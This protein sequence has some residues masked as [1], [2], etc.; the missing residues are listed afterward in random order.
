MNEEQETTS[1]ET[2]REETKP[3]APSLFRNFVSF[4]G[5]AVVVA[6]LTSIALLVLV[7]FSGGSDNPYTVLVTYILLPSVMGFGFLVATVGAL[8][9]RRRRR[10]SPVSS[11]APY[12]ILDLNDPSRRRSLLALIAG[13]FVFLF[14]SAFGS[15]RAFEYTES[16]SFCGEQCHTV[17]KPEFISH[18][19]APHASI[20]C[21]DCHVG[22]GPEWY[23]RSKMNGMRQLYAVAFNTYDRPI[24]TPI[25]NMRNANETCAKC[26]WP[27]KYYG[28]KL[29][30]FNHF[31]YDENNTLRQIRLMLKVGGGSP[32]RGEIGGIH[33]HMNLDN[34]ITYIAADERRQEIPWVR[35]RT[36]DGEVIEYTARGAD[37]TAAAIDAAEKRT[38][39][40]IDCHNRPAHVY[41]SPNQAVD[42][43]LVAAR[44]DV[45]LPFLKLKAVE[46]LARNYSTESEAVAAIMAD[47]P[48]YYRDTHPE[49]YAAKRVSVDAAASEI[50]TI[51]RTYFFP[52]MR[53]NWSSHYDNIGHFTAQG[54]FRCHDGQHVSPQGRVIRN[55]CAIC[56]TTLDQTFAGQ[57]IVPENGIFQHPVNLGDRGAWQCAACHTGDRAFQ[58]PLNL[59]DISRFQCADCHTGPGYKTLK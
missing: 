56:H 27:E 21:V 59:G 26:H 5:L 40:C 14:L 15:Y 57:R 6:A 55:D 36:K 30:V 38:M 12:P 2:P 24:K 49:V 35:M 19:A 20:R 10:R 18:Q 4:A 51:Y 17:M 9:E 46:V 52:E 8:I 31:G 34:E 16:V 48:A 28:E 50:A 45:S 47:L 33:W 53:T 22:G 39:D 54:C 7:E 58:H 37:L 44:L 32:E 29:K 41:L 23:V 1:E 43:A 3:K 42:Q 25:H 11:I 13:G